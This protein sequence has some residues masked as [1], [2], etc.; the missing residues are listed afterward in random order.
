MEK[1]TQD[2]VFVD[3]SDKPAVAKVVREGHPVPQA[4][5]DPA[6]AGFFIDDLI[7]MPP[8][9]APRVISQS[10]KPGTKVVPGTVVDLILAPK[11]IIPFEI[12]EDAHADLRFATLERMD[13][14]V[15]DPRARRFLLKYERA[16]DVPESE[17]PELTQLLSQADIGIVEDDPERNF[18]KA[19]N[20]ARNALAFR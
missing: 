20:T 1:R 18:E 13:P 9:V 10:V 5:L 15:N 19:F 11:Q 8:A 17:R 7:V 6:K 2:F 16:A 14:V 4:R 12:F 3:V